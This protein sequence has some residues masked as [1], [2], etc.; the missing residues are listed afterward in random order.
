M[1]IQ[2]NDDMVIRPEYIELINS[3][4]KNKTSVV[5]NSGRNYELNISCSDFISIL[6]LRKVPIQNIND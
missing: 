6:K 4:G 1:L 5:F 2:I 3:V